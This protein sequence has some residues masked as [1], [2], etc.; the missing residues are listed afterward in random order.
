MQRSTVLALALCLLTPPPS[1]EA[2]STSTP[3]ERAACQTDAFR[4]CTHAMPDRDRV[5]AC[6]R[7]HMPR[8]NSL[9]R[10]ALQRSRK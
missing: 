1:A 8:L 2:Q 7:Q 9:C 10:G 5:R 3:A 6:L 4:L